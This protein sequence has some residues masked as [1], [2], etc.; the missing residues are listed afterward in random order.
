MTYKPH[1][2][3]QFTNVIPKFSTSE[4]SEDPIKFSDPHSLI[5][6]QDFRTQINSRIYP[7]KA[8]GGLARFD[9]SKTSR[10]YVNLAENKLSTAFDLFFEADPQYIFYKLLCDSAFR[11]IGVYFDTKDNHGKP[12]V[13]FHVDTRDERVT[14]CRINKKYYY[15]NSHDNTTLKLIY[16]NLSK[17]S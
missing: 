15:V 4:F 2:I 9:G 16:E 7:S 5:C 3:E 14:Q 10:H 17:Q 12:S 8:T 11:G 13:M 6:L 1:T